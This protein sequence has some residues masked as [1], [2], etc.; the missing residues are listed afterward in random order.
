MHIVKEKVMYIIKQY[1][2]KSKKK[3]GMFVAFRDPD[4]N[5]VKAGY[6][7]CNKK[8]QFD[9]AFAEDVAFN[10]ASLERNFSMPRSLSSK[11][12]EFNDRCKRYFKVDEVRWGKKVELT[13]VEPAPIIVTP[14][15]V[16]EESLFKEQ[17]ENVSKS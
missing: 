10:R 8:D 4:D 17:T 7:L 15:D 1:V 11:A 3:V 16:F 2:H 13:F 12:I 6:S 14:Q 9:K 5:I